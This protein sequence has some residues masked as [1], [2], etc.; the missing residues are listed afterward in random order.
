M[1]I[2][3]YYC[4]KCAKI[5]EIIVPLVEIDKKIKCPLCK[6]VLKKRISPPK[7]IRIN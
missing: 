2:Y 4:I 5:Y 6:K 7:T 3:D 1:P